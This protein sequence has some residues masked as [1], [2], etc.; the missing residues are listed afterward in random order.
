M[1]K[2]LLSGDPISRMKIVHKVRK[3]L[4]TLKNVLPFLALLF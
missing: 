1:S 2:I 4:R 3:K